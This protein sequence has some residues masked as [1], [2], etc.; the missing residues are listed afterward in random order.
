M[1]WLK[2]ARMPSWVW[3]AIAAI[4][5]TILLLPDNIAQ[6]IGLDVFRQ[7]NRAWIGL[8]LIGG[9]IVFIVVS[10][11]QLMSWLRLRKA[12]LK[13][14]TVSDDTFRRRLESLSGE[15]KR[16]LRVSLEQNSQTVYTNVYNPAAHA[17][18]DKGIFRAPNAVFQTWNCPFIIDDSAWKII[19]SKQNYYNRFFAEVKE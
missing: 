18:V 10:A 4:A 17:L 5:M 8:A 16:L 6:T 3:L 19:K 12:V 2:L 7:D 9:V 14:T 15:E 1:D 11:F 13:N